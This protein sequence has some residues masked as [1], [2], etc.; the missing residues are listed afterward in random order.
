MTRPRRWLWFVAAAVLLAAL[1]VLSIRHNPQWQGFDSASF[2]RGLV[3]LDPGWMACALA[4]IYT[5][6][7]VRALR[8]KA[9]MRSMKPEAGL[10]NIFSA[11][12]IGF[13]AIGVLGR[14]GEMVRPYLVARKE[15]V[16]IPGQVSI[17]L[18]ERCFD[19]L[20]ILVTVGF[21]L[22]R[23]EAAGLRSTPALANALHLGGN[24]VA[25]TLL[26]VLALLVAMR[27]F[28]DPI[29]AWLLA[30]LRFLSPP[31]FAWLERAVRG[32]LEG[33]R[34]LR[35]FRT[36]AWCAFYS[37]A[38]WILI[39]FCYAAVFNAFSAGLRL[40]LLQTLIFMGAVMAGSLVQIPGLGGGIQVASLLVL[41]EMFAVRPEPAAA[42]SLLIWVF[43][44]LAVLPPAI[45]LA[46]YEG[47]S[48]SKLTTLDSM[49]P[50]P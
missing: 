7:L 36:L 17:W 39:A 13:G 38:E 23:V 40:T 22:G 33:S 2:L 27:N 45:L 37:I 19:T 30:R 26:A 21:A 29:A 46:L 8:W 5:T 25:L 47:I 3:S 44:F 9:L 42:I 12:V 20:T 50:P 48:W 4:A 41:T 15:G 18:L 49:P 34:A 6:Y 28:A 35:D 31:R 11:T 14:A 32:F 16:P 24:L 10:W 43:T 1:L